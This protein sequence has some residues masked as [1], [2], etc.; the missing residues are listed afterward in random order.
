MALSNY[1]KNN[2]CICSQSCDVINVEGLK[3]DIKEIIPLEAL[4]SIVEA[5]PVLARNELE[6]ACRQVFVED[7]YSN[8]TESEK[9]KLKCELMDVIFGLGP[10]DSLINDESITEI[11]VNGHNNVF[12]EREGVL[13][14]SDIKFVDDN[15][16][17]VLIDRIIS[18]LGRRIDESSPYV[19]ARLSNGYRVNA[20]IPPISLSGPC[21]TIR[22]F[23]DDIITLE[24]MR[25]FGSVDSSV[26]NY[27]D[28][29]IKL[30]KNVCVS[31][32]T[33]S[34]KT[35]LLNALSVLIPENERIITIE[36]AAELKF[37][38]HVHCVRL[39]ARPKNSEGLGEITI[40]ELVQNSLRMRPD[41]IIVGECRGGEALD[42][43]QAMNTG[44]DGSLTTLHANSTE[45]VINRMVTLV[46]YAVDLPVDAIKGLIFSAFDVI[47]QLSRSSQ[48]KRFVCEISEV[49]TRKELKQIYS[50]PQFEE[51]GKWIN[52]EEEYLW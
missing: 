37:A 48:G 2:Q 43:L 29:M 23:S 22:S 45:D 33:G 10:I 3:N 42:M 31:G 20:I 30:K 4:S 35:T 19:N 49:T 1:I 7:K 44:H 17:R 9:E 36:D 47:V 25:E 34:G 18:P 15:Q 8:L 12:F 40:R 13:H 32:G 26:I 51:E 24:K 39:E 6:S 41:R 46:R 21:M 27:F 38:P 16:V 50:R 11:I 28:K 52:M 14:K 5:N